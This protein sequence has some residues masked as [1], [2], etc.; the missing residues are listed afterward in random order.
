MTAVTRDEHD[1]VLLHA[2]DDAFE[3]ADL[4]PGEHPPPDAM[5]EEGDDAEVVAV[6]V[7]GHLVE[8]AARL[9]GD[10]LDGDVALGSDR[11]HFRLD[12]VAAENHVS[13]LALRA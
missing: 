10:L 12:V 13:H 2:L 4:E 7:G 3:T 6:K 8:V 5:E 9:F 11:P 1:R